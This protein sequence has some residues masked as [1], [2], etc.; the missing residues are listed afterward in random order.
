MKTFIIS[1]ALAALPFMAAPA[2]AQEARQSTKAEKPAWRNDP[3]YSVHNYKHPN[4]AAAAQR[5][6]SKTGV[7]V[8]LPP[9]GNTQV[10]NYKMPHINRVPAGGITVPH[11]PDMDI[12]NHNYKMPRPIMRTGTAKTEMATRPDTARST[13]GD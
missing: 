11:S 1:I 12:A 3:M 7:T 5:R 2:L 6:A 13:T 9:V 10:A 8:N 4:K